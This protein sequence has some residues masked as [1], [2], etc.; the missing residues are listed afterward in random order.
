MI[1]W[2]VLFSACKPN[3]SSS[4]KSGNNP[5]NEKTVKRPSLAERREQTEV[6]KNL[7]GTED[8]ILDLSPR[9]AKFSKYLEQSISKDGEKLELP[10]DF[11]ECQ[12]IVGLQPVALDS[13]LHESKKH[14]SFVQQGH[15][16]IATSPQSGINPWAILKSVDANWE[17]VKFGVVSGDFSNSDQTRFSLHLKSEGRGASTTGDSEATI[18][19]GFKGIQDIEFEY[20]TG[21]WKLVSWNQVELKLIRSAQAIFQ[22]CL[23]EALPDADSR[24]NAT[25][26]Y[27]DEIILDTSASGVFKLPKEKYVPWTTMTADHVFPSVSV[28]DFNQDGLDDLFLTARWGPCQLLK[29]QGDG[30]FK[31]V[32]EGSGLEFEYL[33]NCA[34]FVDLDNDGDPDAL[35]GRPMEPAVYLRNDDGVFKDVTSELSDL[36]EQKLY[37]V[38]AISASDVN[39]DGLLDVYLSTYPPLSKQEQGFEHQFL[40][41][42]ERKKYKRLKEEN[43]RWVDTP[44]TA[45][46]LLMNR[47]NGRLERHPYDEDISQW[48]RSY[49]SVWGDID[50]DGD[51]DLYVCNDFAPDAVLRNDTSPGS[52][53]PK[54]VEVTKDL[55][56]ADGVGFGMGASFGDFDADGDLDLYVSNM[57]SK[58]GNRIFKKLGSVDERMR[59]AAA[60]CFLFVNEKGNLTQSAGS[61]DSS[62]HVNQVGW[63]YGG[64]WTDLDNDGRLDLYVPTGFFT[65]PKEIAS[66]VD[67]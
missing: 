1:G 22:E 49:Q 58:A 37:F 66:D 64:Q 48:R 3:N 17:T 27:M 55:L 67:L 56:T 15:W 45:N 59:A 38:S 53:Q 11:S 25:R 36:S 31:D 57:F 5:N 39:R 50:G 47:G 2:L 42:F 19:Y 21:Q 32:T 13:V 41:E 44:G 61:E 6:L 40:N 33:V 16:P 62:M 63:S 60:G 4:K 28:V 8:L 26:S 7:I 10:V 65:A 9:L 12:S 46:V 29:N 14:P 51:D 52:D 30:T 24:K 35:I 54:F 20:Q 34:L 23:A 18:R 43:A